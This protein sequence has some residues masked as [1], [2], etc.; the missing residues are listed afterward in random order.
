M[1]KNETD[2]VVLQQLDIRQ[3]ALKLTA[4]SMYGCLGFTNSR[5]YAQPLAELI[6]RKGRETLMKTV[7]LARNSMN[8]EVI[9]GDTDSIMINS[10]LDN[11]EKAKEIGQKVK[12]EV[13]KGHKLL[14]IEI[15]GIFKT[16]LLLKKKKYAALKVIESNGKVH[17]HKETKGL[18]LV[19]RDWCDLSKEMGSYIL[20][21]ILSGKSR[22]EVVDNIHSYLR[23]KGEQIRSNGAIP[24][25]KFVVTKGLTKAP[26]DYPDAKG[27]PHVQVALRLKKAVNNLF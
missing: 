20:D 21:E 15:D 18:D 2:P 12:S 1:A 8:L 9:Y 6:T 27:Q 22:D 10:G 5:F 23:Q 26:E 11:L 25:E 19:R 3:R 13:N 4:N 24:I 14:E 7:D 17:L 16:L